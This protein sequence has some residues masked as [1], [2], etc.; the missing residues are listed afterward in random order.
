MSRLISLFFRSSKVSRFSQAVPGLSDAT[1]GA[2]DRA[3]ASRE[4]EGKPYELFLTPIM[5][6]WRATRVAL[7]G[8]GPAPD[9]NLERL[10][11]LATAGALAATTASRRADRL[12]PP[13]AR[14]SDRA[15]DAVQVITEGL[16]LAAFSGDRYK[17]QDRGGPAPEQMRSSSRRRRRRRRSRR[18]MERGRILGESSNLA[19]EL[20]NEPANI[21]TPSVFAERGAAI[22]RD[23]G[24]TVEILDED[25]IERL[26]MG[27]L[28]RRLARQ[29]GA[30]A[31]DR[32]DSRARG[33]PRR[34][35]CSGWSARASRST[36]A[37]S[38]S[39]PPTAWSG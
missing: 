22:A 17:S 21:L 38:R 16:M 12:C 8:A 36:P 5:Q 32:H 29:R 13:P 20:C 35:R 33:R 39:S 30:A 14:T 2:I 15:V 28:A 25:E 34:R 7:I 19:R 4:I 1:A 6:G 24:L 10:R 27:L 9:V 11:R 3:L 23:A 18:A 31:R 26:H 37:A